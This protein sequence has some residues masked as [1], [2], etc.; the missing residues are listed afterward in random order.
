MNPAVGRNVQKKMQGTILESLP[1]FLI[2][3]DVIELFLLYFRVF[4]ARAALKR[5][6]KQTEDGY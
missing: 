4:P 2:P 1:L 3:D 5:G 6:E